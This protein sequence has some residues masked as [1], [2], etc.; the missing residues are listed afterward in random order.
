MHSV[1]NVGRP[2]LPTEPA[3]KYAGSTAS[4]FCKLRLYGGGPKYIQI[5]RRVVYDLDDIDEW[6]D[7]HKRRS[8]SVGC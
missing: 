6:L 2:K 4:T 7:A 5:G 1:M 8:T 3:A